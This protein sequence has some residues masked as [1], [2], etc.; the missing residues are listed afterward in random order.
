MS[1]QKI[2]KFICLFKNYFIPLYIRAKIRYFYGFKNNK[3]TQL[4]AN[5]FGVM[6]AST[7]NLGDLVQTLAQIE[8]LKKIAITDY[9]FVDREKLASYSGEPINLLMSGWYTHNLSQFPPNS[10]INPIFIS[11]HINQEKIIRSNYKFFLKHEPIGCRDESTVKLF[12]QYGIKAYLTKCLTLV[13]DQYD[14]ARSGTYFVDVFNPPYYIPSLPKKFLNSLPTKFE[15]EISHE[16][17]PT[18]I[19]PEN[20]QAKLQKTRELLEIYK[21]ADLIVTTRLHCALPC[22]A[23]GTPVIFVHK[24]YQE[25]RRFSGLH[26]ELNGSDGETDFEKLESNIDYTIIEQDKKNLLSD[27]Q[28]R[29]NTIMS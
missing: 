21:K 11:I 22:R 6:Y 2:K 4:K 16:V 18:P 7:G 15:K 13:F 27:L 28:Q 12:K 17:S 29:I 24:D 9:I 14:K 23:F 1:I 8:A 20:L 5:K 25:D 3:F 19:K 10:N 26:Q